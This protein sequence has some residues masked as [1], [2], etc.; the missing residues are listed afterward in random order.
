MTYS[1]SKLLTLL[2]WHFH[3]VRISSN[4]AYRTYVPN[5]YHITYTHKLTLTNLASFVFCTQKHRK[6][7]AHDSEMF[8]NRHFVFSRP[9]IRSKIEKKKR[10][11]NGNNEEWMVLAKVIFVKTLTDS[12]QHSY[13][14]RKIAFSKL[15][16]SHLSLAI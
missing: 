9:A 12:I 6:G 8:T 10:S 15:T 14:P 5:I 7:F 4:C 11:K 13:N 2:L 1:V 3:S 16:F